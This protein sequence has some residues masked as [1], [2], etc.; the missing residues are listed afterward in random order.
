MKNRHNR[1]KLGALQLLI[2]EPHLMKKTIK[3]I[4]S[5]EHISFESY[6]LYFYIVLIMFMENQQ[7][8]K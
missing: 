6:Y 4:S 1:L 2:F 3:T 7:T 5:N 8:K